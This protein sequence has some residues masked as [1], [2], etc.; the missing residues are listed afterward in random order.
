MYKKKD[1]PV[2]YKKVDMI[3]KYKIPSYKKIESDDTMVNKN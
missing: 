2:T 3:R 1:M